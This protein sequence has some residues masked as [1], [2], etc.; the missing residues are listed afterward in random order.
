MNQLRYQFILAQIAALEEN[1][2]HAHE[3]LARFRF[4]ETA[5]ERSF[6]ARQLEILKQELSNSARIARQ[7]ATDLPQIMEM[8]YE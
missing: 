5:S 4:P 6:V 1:N 3:I 7:L 2:Q 8:T